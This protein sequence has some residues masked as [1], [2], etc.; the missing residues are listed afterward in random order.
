MMIFGYLE[1][2]TGSLI[3]QALLGGFAGV[4]VA[5]KAWRAKLAGR[6]NPAPTAE[7]A[8]VSDQA[9]LADEA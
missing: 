1:P 2:G 9:A 7:S 4:V 8:E 6:K 5:Y 3:L